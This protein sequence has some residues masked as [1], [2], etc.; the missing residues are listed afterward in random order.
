MCEACLFDGIGIKSTFFDNLLSFLAFM[1]L[2]DPFF[3]NVPESG[4][5]GVIGS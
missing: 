1:E 4:V 3:L 5:V 2:K